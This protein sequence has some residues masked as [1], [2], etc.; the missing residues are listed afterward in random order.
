M[1]GEEGRVAMQGIQEHP[2]RLARQQRN[3]SMQEVADKTGLGWQTIWRAEQGHELRPASKRLLCDFFGMSA[4]ELGLRSSHEQQSAGPNVKAS[5]EAITSLENEGVDMHRSRR[6][7]LQFLGNTSAG[8]VGAAYLAANGSRLP[9]P[10][11]QPPVQATTAIDSLTTLTQNFRA[12]QRAGFAIESNLKDQI[13]LIQ[14]TLENTLS[15]GH[16]RELWRLLAQTQLLARHSITSKAELGRARTYNE[17]AIASA[18]YSGD[19]LL[20]GATLGHLGH[21]YLI[22]LDDTEGARQILEQAQGYAKD[23]PVRGW[24]AMVSAAVSAKEG[25]KKPCEAAINQALDTVYGLPQTPEFTD[26]YYTDF[27]LMGVNAYAGNNLLKIGEPAQALERL[28]AMDLAAL[29]KNRHASAYHDIACAYVAM[30]ELEAAQSYAVQS[31]DCA[32]A[33]DR[34]YIVP[35]F[36]NLARQI[37]QQ[38][39]H[40][41]HA[42]SILE[43]AQQ[44]LTKKGVVA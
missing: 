26:L 37:Q 14:R 28:Q 35:R 8:A 12:L 42:A 2:L 9:A 22:W 21:L 11:P 29:S 10:A 43:Y 39:P 17:A 16:R 5:L 19:A 3:L 20:F 25:Q 6:A 40:E 24:L 34:A 36:I 13:A 4:E 27:N 38:D 18:Q 7:F 33:T 31:I 32:L 23:H 15:E 30:G 1:R 44:A 41:T